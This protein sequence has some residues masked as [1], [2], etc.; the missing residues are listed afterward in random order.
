MGILRKD[1]AE[2]DNARKLE[3]REHLKNAEKFLKA[4]NFPDAF[5]EVERTLSIDPK[6]FYARA[7]KER[8]SLAKS[9]AEM[10]IHR[11]KC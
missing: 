7:Y 2:R 9:K 10:T 8:I 4:G 5:N 1:T 3:A 6:N 11:S